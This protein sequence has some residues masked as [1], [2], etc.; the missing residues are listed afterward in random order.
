MVIDSKIKYCGTLLSIS[1]PPEKSTETKGC[2]RIGI[3]GLF[4][5]VEV[6]QVGE[7]VRIICEYFVGGK[8]DL[9]E[10]NCGQI[11]GDPNVTMQNPLPLVPASPSDLKILLDS[12]K[13]KTGFPLSR[14]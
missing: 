6:S 2:A 4:P 11:D 1:P 9:I 5:I 14:E 8:C 13:S 3:P 7:K 10:K 12:L